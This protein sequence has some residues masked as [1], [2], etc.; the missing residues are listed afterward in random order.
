MASIRGKI[1][2]ID[3]SV[4]KMTK[5]FLDDFAEQLHIK[6]KAA[7]SLIKQDIKEFIYNELRNSPTARSLESGGNLAYNFGLTPPISAEVVEEICTR[8]ADNIMLGYSKFRRAGLR[9]VGGFKLGIIK[10]DYSDVLKIHNTE[11]VSVNAKGESN[12]VQ[13]LKWL[14]LE[15]D[16]I[17]VQNYGI[18]Y[19]NSESSRSG[20]AL[21]VKKRGPYRVPPEFSGTDNDNWLIRE[22]SGIKESSFISCMESI[23]LKYL[24]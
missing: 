16:K 15:G 21:M 17:V 6:A 20:A 8:S 13:W 1:K 24:K 2:Y 10:A 11:Y 23:F 14:L 5:A 7:K 19:K 18:I 3:F 12:P 9:I 4:S 22:F